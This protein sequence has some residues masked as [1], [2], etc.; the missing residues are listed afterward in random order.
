[1]R[2]FVGLDIDEPIRERI[3]SYIESLRPLVPEIRF[4]AP[5]SLHATLKFIGEFP[6]Q[7]LDELKSALADVGG[8][9]FQ[10][11]FRGNGFFTPRSPRVFWVGIDAGHELRALASAVDAATAKVGVAHEEREFSPHLTLA[12]TGSGRPQGAK[13]DRVKPVMYELRAR[14]EAAPQPDFG[15]MTAREFF[16]YESKTLASGAQYRKLARFALP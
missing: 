2:L 5:E 8:S 6:E 12:R 15:T 9:A 3:R 14:L 11:S 7:R 13:R 16:L 1:M 4:V 10:L